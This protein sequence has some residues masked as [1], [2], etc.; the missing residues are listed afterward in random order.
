MVEFHPTSTL[1]TYD[2]TLTSLCQRCIRVSPT[3]DICVSRHY[4]QSCINDLANH[5]QYYKLQLPIDVRSLNQ[6][7]RSISSQSHCFGLCFDKTP[8]DAF[9]EAANASN[10]FPCLLALVLST[11]DINGI[12]QPLAAPFFRTKT[13]SLVIHYIL[14]T[15]HGL[16]N[17]GFFWQLF[18]FRFPALGSPVLRMPT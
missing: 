16:L 1:T 4:I 18:I 2:S 11:T 15:K 13:H 8:P 3:L 9:Y 17:P 12:S 6:L 14:A 5:P 10:V 7:F